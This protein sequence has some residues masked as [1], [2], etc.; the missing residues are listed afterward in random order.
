[1]TVRIQRKRTGENFEFVSAEN[2]I[3]KLIPSPEGCIFGKDFPRSVTKRKF[4]LN[5]FGILYRIEPL[6]E[7]RIPWC[8]ECPGKVDKF[9]V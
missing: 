5:V 6:A 3:F 4:H 9:A 8:Q 7:D 1:M 2:T